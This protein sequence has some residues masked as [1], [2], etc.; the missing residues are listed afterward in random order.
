MASFDPN[1]CWVW[2]GAS[3]GSGY[4]NVRYEGNSVPAHRLAYRLFVGDIPSGMD[5]CHS[6][7]N[8]ACV[9]PDH[10][11]VGTRADNMR[12]AKRKGRLSRGAKH[13]HAILNGVRIPGAKLSAPQV[14]NVHAHDGISEGEFVRIRN[15]RDDAI[16]LPRLILPSVQVNIRAGRLP[17]A[18]DNGVSYLKVPLNAL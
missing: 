14:I 2:R 10:L 13:S 5:I 12:D 1:Q 11:F 7:D 3:K 6:C 16:G 15:E 17:P 9:N 18:E 4:G 8:R